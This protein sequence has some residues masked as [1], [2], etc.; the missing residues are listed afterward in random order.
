MSFAD[1]ELAELMSQSSAVSG[2]L[3]VAA[4]REGTAERARL[5]PP[6]PEMHEV[7]ELRIGALGARLYLPRSGGLPIVVFLHGGGW[8]VGSLDTHDR[9]CRRLSEGS[10][11]AL[12]AVDYRLAPEHRW[13]ASVDDTVTALRFVRSGLEVDGPV[14]VAGDSAG[15]TLATLACLRLR[16]Q[17][18]DALPGLQALLYPN[19]DLTGAHA[20]MREKAVG[21]GLTAD[22]VRFFNSQWVPEESMWSDPRVSPLHAPDLHGLPPA[23]IV[24]AEHDPLRDEGEAYAERLI[25]AGNSV[26]LRREEG[27]VHS[28]MLM[29]HVSPACA[30]AVDR[31]AADLRARLNP[32]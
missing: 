21:F 26:Q 3:H 4:M 22:G 25:Q 7:R 12:L 32:R 14:A 18:P 13:P 15:G 2:D 10:G 1:P 9:A 5:R 20:S 17:D 11:C 27:L 8:T 30:A 19:T 23:L 28:F 6:G 31:I 24:T 16:D 29:D